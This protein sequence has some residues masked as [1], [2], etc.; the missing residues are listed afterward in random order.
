MI[1]YIIIILLLQFGQTPL[2]KAKG[3]EVVQALKK[4]QMKV[5][6]TNNNDCII[7][8]SFDKFIFLLY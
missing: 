1:Y 8:D 5:Y 6:S 4:Q 7:Y 3:H 2:D